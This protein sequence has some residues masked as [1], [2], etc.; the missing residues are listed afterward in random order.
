MPWVEDKVP[1]VFVKRVVSQCVPS[2]EDCP[3]GTWYAPNQSYE[4]GSGAR[5]RSLNC[6]DTQRACV[7]YEAYRYASLADP[8][9]NAADCPVDIYPGTP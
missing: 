6:N 4:S 5:G 3:L 7:P 8:A 9:P 2:G 1:C